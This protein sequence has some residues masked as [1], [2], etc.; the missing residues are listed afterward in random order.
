[1][2][3]VLLAERVR[4]DAQ[5]EVLPATAPA[6]VPLP[7]SSRRGRLR[8]GLAVGAALVGVLAVAAGIDLLRASDRV[9]RPVAPVD[10][11]ATARWVAAWQ[12]ATQPAPG[13]PALAGATLRMLVHPQ[14]TGSQVRVRLSN[15]YGMEALTIGTTSAGRSDGAAGLVPGTLRPITF[16]GREEV[17][18]PAGAD[19]VSDP[20]PL[21]AEA[22]RPIAVSLYLPAAP[23]VVTQHGI[24]LQTSY[25]A[26]GTDAALWAAGTAFDTP[27]RSWLVLTGVDVLAPRPENAVIAVGD[28]ITDGLGSPL[29]TDTR[30]SDALATRLARTGGAA[31]MAVLNAGISRNRLLADNAM[32]D[33]DSPLTRFEREVSTVPGASDVVLHIGTND[34]ADGRTTDEITAGMVRYAQRAHGAGK[35]IIFTTITPS[36]TGPHGTPAALAVRRAVNAWVLGPGRQHADGVY[37][38]ATAVADPAAPDRLAP[39]FDAGD[40]LHLSAAG[41]QALADVV[42]IAQLSGSPCLADAS[43]AR[44]LLSD[45]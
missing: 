43:P 10:N 28:S 40:G 14:V 38:F 17:V 4:P 32:L 11:C 18:I 37:D 20:V 5:E 30:W 21:V 15:A 7:V 13:D 25:L 27:V 24:A 35:R 9:V 8:A 34:V 16:G 33:G 41:Y 2:S 3:G 12:T 29:D 26:R 45:G 1:M 31:G 19:M 22:G 39:P 23:A 6:P 36:A 42:D 44:I